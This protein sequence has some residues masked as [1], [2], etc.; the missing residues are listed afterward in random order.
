M[1]LCTDCNKKF[2][3]PAESL[4]RVH[5]PFCFSGAIFNQEQPKQVNPKRGWSFK[6]FYEEFFGKKAVK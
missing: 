5:C 6:N 1:W 2:E 4:I 3:K